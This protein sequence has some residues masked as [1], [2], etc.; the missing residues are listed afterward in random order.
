MVADAQKR[1]IGRKRIPAAMAAFAVGSDVYFSSSMRGGMFLMNPGTPNGVK[2]AVAEEVAAAIVRCQH[3]YTEE[4]RFGMSCA[5]PFA[6]HQWLVNNQQIP[7]VGQGKISTYG[8]IARKDGPPLGIKDP[9]S[10][11]SDGLWGC[12]IFLDKLQIAKVGKEEDQPDLPSI[13]PAQAL[14]H[15]L[16]SNDA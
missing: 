10:I 5:E 2:T 16:W 9:C 13:E 14:P 15:C 3:T 6:I 1:R 12:Q 8:R 4:Q 7:I 11:T